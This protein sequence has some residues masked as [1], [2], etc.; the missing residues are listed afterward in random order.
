MLR[1]TKFIWIVFF[2]VL[3]FVKWFVFTM[4]NVVECHE[5]III[6]FSNDHVQCELERFCVQSRW[7]CKE[8][9][10]NV[11]PVFQCKHGRSFQKWKN[12]K[13][14]HLICQPCNPQYGLNHQAQLMNIDLYERNRMRKLSIFLV[15]DFYLTIPKKKKT[16]TFT[17]TLSND[18]Q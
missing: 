18:K 1:K 17:F 15:F 4:M 2:F 11:N 14:T 3:F 9:I 16:K 12:E 6:L 8:T 13:P 10:L 7:N 5:K